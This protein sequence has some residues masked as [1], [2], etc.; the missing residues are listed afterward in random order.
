MSIG[1]PGGAYCVC[2]LAI[3]E[4][5]PAADTLESGGEGIEVI[6]TAFSRLAAVQ[7]FRPHVGTAVLVLSELHSGSFGDYALY[8]GKWEEIAASLPE[9]GV[10]CPSGSAGSQMIWAC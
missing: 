3:E 4:Q 10:R 1:D 7:A 9:T 5:G 2:V 8:R 6:R